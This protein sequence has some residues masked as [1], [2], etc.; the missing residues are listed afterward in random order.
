MFLLALPLLTI[1]GPILLVLL[2]L[3]GAASCTITA[4]RSVSAFG[5]L[6]TVGVCRS[7]PTA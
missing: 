5:L 6:V 1:S 2:G 3:G 7:G 4:V